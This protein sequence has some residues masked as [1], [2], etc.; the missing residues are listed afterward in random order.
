[1]RGIILA[2]GSGTRLWP[3]T[4]GISKQLMPIYDKP[5]VYYPLSTLMMAGINE[6]LIITT[7]EYNEQFRA[8][9]GDG[10]ALGHP[11]RVRGAAEPRRPRTGVHHRRGV[12]RRRFRRAGAGRQHLPRHGAGFRAPPQR[13]DRRC[14]DLRL[15]GQQSERLRRRRV[16]RA[17]HG[18]LHRGEARVAQEQVRR[19]GPL[20]L[21]QQRGRDRQDDRAER[22]RRARDLDRQR[23][24]PAGRASSRSRCS[25]AAP[26]GSTPAR[27]SR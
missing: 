6:I 14:G 1:M 16:R 8:L 11:P 3:I 26:H 13:A 23:A 17:Q 10:S 24:L 2:G 7:P 19:A 9:L 25:T 12:H 21:R 27:S 5:M 22:T 15:P 20:L 18:D 4:K